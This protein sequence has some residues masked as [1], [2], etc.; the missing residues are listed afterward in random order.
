MCPYTRLVASPLRA[1]AKTRTNAPKGAV[2]AVVAL[3]PLCASGETVG[4]GP[5][6]T[7]VASEFVREK[8][9]T[10]SDRLHLKDWQITIVMVRRDELKNRTLGGIRWDKS[11]KSAVISVLDPS[12]YELPDR[13]MLDDMEFTVVHELIHL[14]LASLPKSEAS[15]SR[16]EF[17]VNQLAEALLRLDRQR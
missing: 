5:D 9:N 15:R 13:E 16:E 7:R 3:L 12:G 4:A 14:E 6:R 8:L 2:L 11:K 10:W 1:V 17:A